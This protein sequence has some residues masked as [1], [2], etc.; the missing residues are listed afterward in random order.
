MTTAG[1]KPSV[2]AEL[3][4]GNRCMLRVAGEHFLVKILEV[5]RAFIRVTFPGKDYPIE[6]LHV[7]IEFHDESGFNSYR[8][9]VVQGPDKAGGA[10]VLARP[11]ESRRTKYRD[12]C[13]VPTDLTVHVKDQVHVRRYDAA[14]VNIGAGGALIVTPA[15]FDFAA[16][17]EMQLSLPGEP[18]L[19]LIGQIVHAT[20]SPHTY[21]SEDKTYGVRFV[22]IEPEAASCISRYVWN[23]LREIYSST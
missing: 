15:H 13:R 18:Q 1:G 19:S 22:S 10:L 8:T 20:G 14:L 12:S 17:I 5:E 7:L 9:H 2:N 21:R 6:G 16:T 4:V 23:R 11:V 3:Y